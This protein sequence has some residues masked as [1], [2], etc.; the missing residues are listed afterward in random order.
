FRVTRRWQLHVWELSGAADTWEAQL[1]AH[2][3]KEPVF[4]VISGIGGRSWAPVHRFCEGAGL[5]CLMPNVDLPDAA[6]DDFYTVYFSRG[7]LL[8]A[9]LIAHDLAARSQKAQRIGLLFRA[10]DIGEQAAAAFSA[11]MS[12]S[13]ATV[14]SRR[15]PARDGADGGRPT[16]A[17]ARRRPARRS[18]RAG[19]GRC[20][21]AV[22]APGRSHG[23]R[24]AA[25]A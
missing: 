2:L 8:E 23:A 15:L 25:A 16:P 3:A 12:A 14:V 9:E 21:G 17:G 13:G 4:A 5:P 19:P 22:A 20:V 10:G 1:A 18:R 24:A 11:A 7:V 6:P